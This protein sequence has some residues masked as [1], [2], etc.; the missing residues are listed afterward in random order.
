MLPAPILAA[1]PAAV[2]PPGSNEESLTD[3]AQRLT[4]HKDGRRAVHL[5][6]SLLS[7]GTR[8]K[9]HVRIVMNTFEPL[10]RRFEGRVFRLWNDDIIVGVKDARISD[11]DDYVIKV[12]FLFSEDPLL[13]M[14]DHS[15]L[16]FCYWYD[17][18]SDH[19]EFLA[20]AQGLAASAAKHYQKMA[21]AGAKKTKARKLP[22][23]QGNLSPLTPSLL[24]RF[25]KSLSGTDLSPLIERQLIFAVRENGQPVPVLCEHFISIRAMQQK[26]M[27]GVDCMSDRWLF[28]R[29]CQKL[30][31]RMLAALPQISQKIS[32]PITL[33]ITINTILSPEFQVF[34]TAI[35]KLTQQKMILEVQG[36]DL[37]ADMGAYIFARD[38][39]RERGYG[40]ALDGLNPLTFPLLD[41]ARLKLDFEKIIWAPDIR[42]ELIPERK[43]AFIDAIRQADPRR[44]ILCRCDSQEA[45]DFGLGVGI[46]LFQGRHLDRMIAK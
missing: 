18:E 38:F 45:I 7:P 10:L 4:N 14:E 44:I 24:D 3:Y 27:P 11:I 46:G 19:S 5:R 6:L 22:D 40:I 25:E 41:R 28:Q 15:A 37:F 43:A 29:L 33:N 36:I 20:L 39:A 9:H 30:D 2:A 42:R 12:Q 32:V 1:D 17:M 16:Q 35:R 21:A 31:S 34:D 23:S 13:L 26:F 8:M